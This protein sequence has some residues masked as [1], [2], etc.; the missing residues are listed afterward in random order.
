MNADLISIFFSIYGVKETPGTADSA[1]IMQMAKET[2]FPE[3]VHDSI[4]WCSLTANWVALKAGYER[5]KSL[6]ARS[7]LTTGQPVDAPQIGDIVVL[8]R[9]DPH[10]PF[11]H[12]GFYINGYGTP[13][14]WL[15]AGNQGDMINIE[16][17]PITRVL[18]YR[19]L[20]KVSV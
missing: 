20:S 1:F 14:I 11:G 4:P 7:W 15:G 16:S 9:D 6:T 2:G 12:V 8:W 18:G 17:F 5:S 13:T 10:G 19:R 3:Y